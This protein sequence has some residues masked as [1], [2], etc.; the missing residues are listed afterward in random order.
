MPQADH[1]VVFRRPGGDQVG[2]PE[3]LWAGG[4]GVMPIFRPDTRNQEEQEMA[5]LEGRPN[6]CV[7]RYDLFA[8][9]AIRA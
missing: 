5:D 4:P 3:S 6:A 7:P 8:M 2:Y 1:G 9:G